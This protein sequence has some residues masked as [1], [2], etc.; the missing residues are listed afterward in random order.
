MALFALDE[1]PDFLLDH[2]LL[3]E[4]PEKRIGEHWRR[5]VQTLAG[6]WTPAAG[7]AL[8][9]RFHWLPARGETRVSLAV[10]DAVAEPARLALGRFGI[11]PRPFTPAERDEDARTWERLERAVCCEVRQDEARVPIALP[12]RDAKFRLPEPLIV[13]TR[14]T[15]R[16]LYRVIPWWAPRR[17]VG[18][19]IPRPGGA[20]W[21]TCWATGPTARRSRSTTPTGPSSGGSPLPRTAPIPFP[22][23]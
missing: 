21:S 7:A 8:A 5:W 17:P 20:P 11:A 6:L 10:P 2:T 15:D 12:E 1:I 3:E 22:T 18:P 23:R 9:L 13:G 4:Q 14:Q 16:L 19:A